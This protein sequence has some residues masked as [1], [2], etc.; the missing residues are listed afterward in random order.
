VTDQGV[1]LLEVKDLA[2]SFEVYGGRVNAVDGVSLSIKPGETLGIVG[3]SGSGKSVMAYSL[4]GLLA[5]NGRIDRGSV[6]FEGRE[7]QG[8]RRNV[9]EVRGRGIAFIF[10]NPRAALNPIRS[11][12]DQV[13]D[14][15]ETAGRSKRRDS[16][17]RALELLEQVRIERA[18]ERFGAFPHELS[19]GMCQRV[20]IAMALAARP[21]LLIAD[22]PTTGL[23]VT[24]QRVI[25]DTL[26]ELS[27]KEGLATLLITHDVGL[28]ARYCRRI[29]VMCGGKVVETG[30]TRNVLERSENAYTQ[31]LVAATPQVG[32][33]L[34]EL[35]PPAERAAFAAGTERNETRSR[36]IA[37]LLA[38]QDISKTFESSR[39]EGLFARAFRRLGGTAGTESAIGHYAVRNVS[40]TLARGER[41]GIV[42]ESGSG[43]TTMSRMIA[44]LLDHTEGRI[45]FDGCDIGATPSASFARSAVRHRIQVVFQDPL[46]SLNP[47]FTAYEAICNPLRRSESTL[48]TNDRQKRIV[49]AAR[50]AGLD[51]ALLSRFPHQLSGGQQAR[52]GIARALVVKPELLILDEP[53][54]ALDVSV[55]AV[56][57]NQLALLQRQLGLTYILISHDLNVIRLMCDRVM[58]MRSGRVVELNDVKTI[59]SAPSHP[60]TRELIDAIPDLSDSIMEKAQ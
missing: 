38:V 17:R 39:S 25:M 33:A 11:V 57:L 42:G 37:P 56:V 15:L 21:K 35:L 28:A 23:D 3:E 8:N 49:T 10:Q 53:T 13:R 48:S 27:A 24:T 29:A 18:R 9:A 20:L 47:R 5:G 31:R 58:V 6:R 46:G 43:K 54:S 26:Y 14:A 40:L 4:V 52:V 44:R 2:V 7:L 32:R 60:Y 41:F 50:Q 16:A 34:I 55:Q 12:G 59:F 30:S 19:G 36:S 51:P 45:A 1:P 22:E